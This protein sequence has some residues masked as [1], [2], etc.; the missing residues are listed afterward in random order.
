MTSYSH[1][2]VDASHYHTNFWIWKHSIRFD[3]L[4]LCSPPNLLLFTGYLCLSTGYPLFK[5]GL[6]TGYLLFAD[7]LLRATLSVIKFW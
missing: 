4:S 1:E 7:G 2:G 5:Y 3:K 6:L